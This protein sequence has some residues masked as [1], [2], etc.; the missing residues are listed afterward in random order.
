MK[1]VV[2]VV[3]YLICR[4]QF[5]VCLYNRLIVAKKAARERLLTYFLA[6]LTLLPSLALCSGQSACGGIF[7]SHA[8]ERHKTHI[9]KIGIIIS[10]QKVQKC[11]YSLK[12]L[13]L[14]QNR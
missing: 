4:S 10:P 5:I 12:F 11:I 7:P 13:L 1:Y 9:C 3:F 8:L 6:H 2:G 14:E